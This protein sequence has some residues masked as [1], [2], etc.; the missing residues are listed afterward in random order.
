[1][2]SFAHLS[3]AKAQEKTLTTTSGTTFSK[4]VHTGLESEGWKDPSGV[5]WSDV[6]GQGNSS[7]APKLMTFSEAEKFCRKL[8]ARVPNV[9]QA[10][11]LGIYLGA[12]RQFSSTPDSTTIRGFLGAVRF[13][14][15]PR[16]Y[17]PQVLA[18]LTDHRCAFW[19]SQ[20]RF[21]QSPRASDAS[22]KAFA[23]DG[24]NGKLIPVRNPTA[25][26]AVRCVW[27]H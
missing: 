27:R 1:M 6:F 25:A 20:I 12:T 18:N 10:A 3:G 17:H 11:Q 14:Y 23:F 19:S 15:S 22:I 9:R 24:V 21:L 8:G 2:A 4:V 16:G 26:H 5:I 7:F 13:R